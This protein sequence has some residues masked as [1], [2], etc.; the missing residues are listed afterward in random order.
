MKRNQR[1]EEEFEKEEG[2]VNKDKSR[3]GK[4]SEI[5]LCD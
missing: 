2:R 1:K 4:R 5:L 3:R